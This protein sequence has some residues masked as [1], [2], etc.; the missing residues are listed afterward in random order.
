[1]R[2]AVPVT[3]PAPAIRADPRTTRPP[4]ILDIIQVVT[5]IA[6]AHP[7]VGVWWYARPGASGRTQV[8]LVLEPRAGARPDAAAITGELATCFGPDAV[9]VRI[10]PTQGDITG[11]YRLLTGPAG[12]S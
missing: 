2:P 9:S 10:R 11:F 12:G 4:A 1:M 5:R 7:E 8:M 6:P 3:S